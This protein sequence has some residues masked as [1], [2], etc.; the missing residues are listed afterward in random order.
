MGPQ[1]R[2]GITRGHEQGMS[3]ILKLTCLPLSEEDK[4]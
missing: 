1:L 3:R 4:S 2:Q